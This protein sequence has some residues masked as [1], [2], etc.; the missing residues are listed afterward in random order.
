MTEPASTTAATSMAAAGVSLA[1]LMPS[2]D[3]NALVGAFAGATLFAVSAHA[4][5]LWERLAYL[6]VSMIGGYLASGELVGWG[7]KS[8]G[9]AAFFASAVIVTLTLAAIERAKSI[10]LFN[11]IRR[12]GPPSA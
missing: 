7:L 4:R 12:G 8:S 6:V 2:M 1:A 10:D 11:W 9:L 3:G 5:P